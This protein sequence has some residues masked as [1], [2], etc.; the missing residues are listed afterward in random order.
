MKRRKGHVSDYAF[1]RLAGDN[2]K[3]IQTVIRVAF[4]ELLKK[5]VRR[6]VKKSGR[7]V[8]LIRFLDATVGSIQPP[9]YI[10]SAGWSSAPPLISEE[11]KVEIDNALVSYAP[12]REYLMLVFSVDGDYA[13][14]YA[15]WREPIPTLPSFELWKRPR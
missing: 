13:G 3:A 6:W 15:W 8:V 5:D 14:S 4:G 9:T 2:F 7:G 12:E 10:E 1:T 11:V